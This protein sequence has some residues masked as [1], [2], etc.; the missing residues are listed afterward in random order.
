[1]NKNRRLLG[2]P[3]IR[4]AYNFLAK[5]EHSGQIFTRE[6]LIDASGWTEQT[7]RANLSKKL[8]QLV[9]RCDGGYRA[10]GVLDLGEEGFC[11]ICSQNSTL[12]GDPRRPSLNAKTEELVLKARESVLAGVQHYNNPTSH[13]RSGNYLVLMIIGFTALFHAIFERDNIDYIERKTDGTP[14]KTKDGEPYHWDARYSA[15]FYAQRYA[16]NYT[17]S[18]LLAVEKNL[19]FILPLRNKIE[20]R[21]IPSLDLDIGGHCQ[22][23]LLNFERILVTEFGKYYALNPSLTLALQF[24]TERSEDT[25]TAVRRLQ[26]VEY[27]SLRE[28]ISSFHADLPDEIA[29]NAAFELRVWLVQK[30]ANRER[31]ADLSLEFV[32]REQLSNDQYAELQR[33]IIAVKAVPE[34]PSKICNLYER[35]VLNQVI[36]E[37]GSDV[38]YG[39]GMRKLN[40]PMV[41]E[42][43]VAHNI[44]SPSKFY[45]RPGPDGSRAYY[46]SA[47]VQWMI[48]QYHKDSDFFFKAR[49]IIRATE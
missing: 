32:P 43:R 16:T 1:M 21:H 8:N 44:Q 6:D 35:D 48:E 39:N 20:H 23:L 19:E 11:R 2:S 27:E 5:A 17:P 10:S 41:R 31:N 34:D 3:K 24:S 46:S 7:T 26:S 14:K 28:Y 42:V 37:L 13:F 12:A 45:Y 15:N 30:P 38:H 18:F 4:A 25:I 22:A 47:F 33:A 40:G 36:A 29:A 9:I 49:Q